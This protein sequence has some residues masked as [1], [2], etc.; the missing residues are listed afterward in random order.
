MA[1]AGEDGF[2]EKTEEATPKKLADMRR[3]GK[4]AQSKELVSA[5][6]VLATTGALWASASWAFNGIGSV[7]ESSFLEMSRLAK[8][9]W[10]AE[11]IVAAATFFFKALVFILAPLGLASVASALLASVSQHG[12]FLWSS[13]P[14]EP[15]LKKLNPQ[16]AVKRIFGPDGIFEVFKAIM[17]LSIVGILLYVVFQSWIPET[18]FLWDAEAATLSKMLGEKIIF[19]MLIIGGTMAVLA[20]ADF[21]FQKYRFGEQAKMTKQEVKEERKQTDG[22]PHIKARMR[23]MQRQ[24]ATNQ[25]LAAV[26][27]ADV[28]ITNPTHYA[29]AL[30]YDRETMMAPK[31]IAKGVDSMAQRIKKIARE[32]GIP[33]VENVP[34][35]RALHKALRIGQ[36]ISKDLYN[37]V[38]EVLA[39]VYR[40]KGRAQT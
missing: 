38:A 8:S 32:N 18:V 30:V 17:K 20:M 24:I 23:S 39:Y 36:F 21:A 4:V 2:E 37:A 28:V 3:E 25:M 12:G 40:L 16:N 33:C 5:V 11:T 14:L 31:V 35:A 29:V 1:A 10:T 9:E 7:F 6:L 19:T 15:D 34:L 26:K 13:K 27:D 22:D